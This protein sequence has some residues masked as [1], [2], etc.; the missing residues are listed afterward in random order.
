M[1]IPSFQPRFCKPIGM[2]ATLFTIGC[3][4]PFANGDCTSVG[5][6]GIAATVVDASTNRAPL[7]VPIMR[8]EDG[9]YIEEYS[10]PFPQSDPPSYAGA[11]ERPG[12]YRV[13]VRAAGYQ[14]Y[15]RSDIRVTRGGR[16][17]SLSGVRLTVSLVRTM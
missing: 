14:D 6:F 9:T 16:C 17:N 13:I 8:I 3:T 12:T 15:V 7:S 1:T 5:V 4:N 11:N 2:I 10:T